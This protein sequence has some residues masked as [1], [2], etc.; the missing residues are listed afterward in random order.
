M[1][2]LF[3]IRHAK[4]SWKDESLTDFE[5]P[6]NKR[7]EKNAPFMGKYLKQEN[8]FPDLIISSKALRAK[9]TAEIIS[10]NIGYPLEKIDFSKDIY[11]KSHS[12]I[13]E[14]IKNLDNKLNIIFLVGHN[15]D[16]N[17][18][19]YNLVNLIE[20]IPTTGV[21]EIEFD[22]NSWKDI[23]NKNSTLKRFVYPKMFN[24]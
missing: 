21:V 17:I 12:M 11:L 13:I 19:A 8:I 9:T 16:L 4:S 2:K 3:I 23:S 15:P 10:S 7:G 5:R 24:D 6:L 22:T 20:N 1:K 18:L 14:D